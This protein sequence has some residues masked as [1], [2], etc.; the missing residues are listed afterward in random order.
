ME[1]VA[2]VTGAV[3]VPIPKA[4]GSYHGLALFYTHAAAGGIGPDELREHLAGL[5]PEYL[6]PRRVQQA[7]AFPQLANG[8][9]D[10]RA[11][12]ATVRAE[13]PGHGPEEVLAGTAAEVADAFRTVLEVTRVP[14][15]V[16]FFELGGS[17]LDAAR[18][19]QQLDERLGAAVQPSQIFRTPTVRRLAEWLDATAR[20]DATATDAVPGLNPGEILLPPEQAGFLFAAAH[21]KDGLGGMCRLTWWLRGRVDLDALEAAA[22]DVHARH[23]AL[24][25]RYLI[26]DNA[27]GYAVVPDDPGAAELIRLPD[28][29]DEESATAAWLAA[30]FTPLSVRDGKVW[31]CAAV[32]ARDTGRVLFGLVA[33]H[34]AFDG[35]SE[36]ILAADLSF[37]YAARLA[38]HAPRF[39]APAATVA[40]V[41]ADHRRVLSRVDLAAQ[42]AY[43]EDQ[44]ELLE[45]LELPGRDDNDRNAGPGYSAARTLTGAELARWDERARALGT[46][47]FAVLAAQFGLVLRALTGQDDI[48]VKVPAARRGSAVL[49]TAVS[50]RV[51]LLY[52][53]FWPPHQESDGGLLER[54]VASTDDALAAQETGGAQ[55]ARTVV[56][57]GGGAALRPMPSFLT[58]DDPDPRLRLPGCTAELYRIGSPTMFTELE[59]DV[60]TTTAGALITATVRTDR[61]PPTVADQVADSYADAL[62]RGPAG[63][64]ARPA[65]PI[66]PEDT[67]CAY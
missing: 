31:R 7:G 28:A 60:R 53:R 20:T 39:A 2:T 24:Y 10:R 19:C 37:A 12:A 42:E 8:K 36:T 59:L 45:P 23:Q 33:H 14:D 1:R 52:L 4:D 17:S 11:L 51:N 13:D 54:A 35:A 67:P 64:A 48:T 43:W 3:V 47:R 29:P 27:I 57:T 22:G 6:V 41:S 55:L 46:T 61:I 38:G 49:A 58:Q 34:V 9:I 56:L 5:L 21:D 16:S 66:T 32:R 15:G 18:L 63:P 62:R 40:E 50:C 25:A 30:A 44:L 65:D 26:R